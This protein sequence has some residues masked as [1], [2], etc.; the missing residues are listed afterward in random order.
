LP[1]MTGAWLGD[2]AL[3]VTLAAVLALLVPV[4]E[5]ALLASARAEAETERDHL[6]RANALQDELVHLIT[7]ELKN[8]LTIVRIYTQL[9]QRALN[10]G[11][12]TLLSECLAGIA[13][14][15]RTLEH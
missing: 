9:G 5:A 4:R 10:S 14:A 1:L 2:G 3:L 13:Q 8:P 15:E 11:S 7:H 12:T 6:A